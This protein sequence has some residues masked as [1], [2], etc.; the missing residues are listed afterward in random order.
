MDDGGRLKQ[1]GVF[2]Q[3]DWGHQLW[4]VRKRRSAGQALETYPQG[5]P[6]PE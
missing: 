6:G 3:K 5:E 2:P 4:D 1:P